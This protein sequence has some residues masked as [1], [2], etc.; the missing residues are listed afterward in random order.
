[1]RENKR[2]F[3]AYRHF[4]SALWCK[5]GIN[6]F[7]TIIGRIKGAAQRRLYYIIEPSDWSIRRDGE[8]IVGYIRDSQP[9]VKAAIT[10][11][12][13]WLYN[14]VLH[15]GSLWAFQGNSKQTHCSNR[16]VTTIFHGHEGLGLGM[17]QAINN[18][19]SSIPQLDSIVTAC[20]IMRERLLTW[21][22][23]DS[24]L[25]VI[26]IGADL[27][28]FRPPSVEEYRLQR[29]RFG[30][31]AHSICIGS[32]QKDGEGWEEGIKPKLIKGPDI[33]LEVV[34]Q[35]S[36]NYPVFVLLTGPARGYVKQRLEA[37]RIPYR[38][39]YISDFSMLP[40][41]YHALDLYLVASREEGGPKAL[42]ESMATGVP[43]VSTR[44]GMAPDMIKD[45][46]NG[47]L[48]E[49]DDVDGLV[50][51]S[52]RLIEDPGLKQTL[53]KNALQ[54]VQ[55]YDWAV[56]AQSYYEKVYAPLLQ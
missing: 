23:P 46:D 54:T 17:K 50:K 26:P 3:I 41:Y 36:R 40:S 21:G 39:D 22:V 56:I 28:I 33:F 16:M 19:L 2:P 44:V 8:A 14:Q 27:T 5:F 52:S 18:L 48:V 30:I 53:T 10:T 7:R 20:T 42:P 11:N 24:K 47:F 34:R 12:S 13:R 6:P 32:F 49:C 55:A 29:Q 4:T 37:A 45:G 15:F 25:H 38:H 35:L 51:A 31:P 1:M 9:Q 43:L